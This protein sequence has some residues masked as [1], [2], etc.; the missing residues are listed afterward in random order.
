VAIGDDSSSM[1]AFAD[2]LP[3]E[4]LRKLCAVQSGE[5]GASL[6]VLC[7][8]VLCSDGYTTHPTMYTVT[9]EYGTVDDCHPTQSQKLG[10]TCR[11]AV[12]I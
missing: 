6:C 7:C 11:S 2:S 1:I 12:T 8:A 4:R 10:W 3:E 9:V 5:Q